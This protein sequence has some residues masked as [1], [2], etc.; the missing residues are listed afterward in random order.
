MKRVLLI[1]PWG[2]NNTSEYLNGLIYGI[3]E[4][5][6]LD[7]FTNYYF[8]LKVPNP[9]CKIHKIFFSKS[10][11]MSSGKKRAILRG[12]EYIKAYNQILR[13][14]RKHSYDVVHINWLLFYPLDIHFLKQIKKQ[15]KQ[16]VYTA[17]NV[18]PHENGEKQIKNLAK[19][20]HI[21]DRIILHG[22][23][24]KKEFM[25]YFPEEERKIFIQN[26]GANLF[27]NV[28]Y[29]INEIPVDVKK[30]LERYERKYICFGNMFYNKGADRLVKIWKSNRAMDSMLLIIA[31]R[32]SNEY[33][34]L[35][36][37][38]ND[39]KDNI[40]FLNQYV[41][42]HLLNFLIAHSQLIVLPY[43]HASMS[44]V[45]FTAADFSKPVLCTDTGAI[46]EY[47]ID[48]ENGIISDNSE[49]AIEEAVLRSFL[50]SPRKLT[51]M[52]E[53]L[54]QH[55]QAEYGWR[56]LGKKIV[57]QCYICSESK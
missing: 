57:E 34:E 2:I 42:D 9:N 29:D 54:H 38:C 43:R 53:K 39:V 21:V 13:H 8:E 41:D 14:L 18:L 31:G 7:V 10:E 40:L 15:C 5:V 4:L 45:I 51:E 23:N 37:L 36:E 24:I 27:P 6:K 1:D 30:H 52:G 22:E 50:L 44:G 48:G 32:V 56:Q 3:S 16:L 25:E 33:Q 35:L 26:H 11:H 20:Y 47:I 19:I 55:I 49:K 28:N 17:H 46:G 12:V